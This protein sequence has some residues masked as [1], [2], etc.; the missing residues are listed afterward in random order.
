MYNLMLCEL[1]HPAMHGKTDD[2]AKDI[3]SHYLVHCIIDPKTNMVIDNNHDCY[4]YNT[5]NDDTDDD[6]TDDDDT[7]DDD[8]YVIKNNVKTVSLNEELNWLTMHSRNAINIPHPTI[9]NYKKIVNSPKY[10]SLQ[11]GEYITLPTLETVAILKTFWLRILQRKW[12]KY[13][14]LSKNKKV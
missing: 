1:H 2:S 3:E 5:D 12:K 7:D 9:R 13:Y 4:D 10:I 8:E 6:N 11:I 14:N